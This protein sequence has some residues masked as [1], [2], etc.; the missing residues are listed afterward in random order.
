MGRGFNSTTLD[1]SDFQVGYSIVD[2]RTLQYESRVGEDG[3][4][5]S[6]TQTIS[7]E[8][9]YNRAVEEVL[10]T[11]NTT[12]F[13]SIGDKRIAAGLYIG[14]C[15]DSSINK[16]KIAWYGLKEDGDM[17][18]EANN[19]IMD[20]L[21]QELFQ[22]Y[23]QKLQISWQ[24]ASR[25]EQL[26][27]FWGENTDK[28]LNYLVGMYATKQAQAD[29]E[30][31]RTNVMDF[32]NKLNKKLE[33]KRTEGSEYKLIWSI[34]GL[35]SI[36]YDPSFPIILSTHDRDNKDAYRKICSA[37]GQYIFW[38][39]A[40]KKQ[41]DT[42]WDGEE[43]GPV[44]KS[45]DEDHKYERDF[46]TW[47][48]MAREGSAEPWLHMCYSNYEYQDT[49]G[50]EHQI[51]YRRATDSK[52]LT[53]SIDVG[54][55]ALAWLSKLY[56]SGCNLQ[57]YRLNRPGHITDSFTLANYIKYLGGKLIV[58]TKQVKVGNE[59]IDCKTY[60]SQI[61]LAY[62]FKK[63]WGAYWSMW[64]DQVDKGIVIKTIK[65]NRLQLV[66]ESGVIA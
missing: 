63:L 44:Y 2:G 51:L 3:E 55:K 27:E 19:E 13:L 18:N 48:K 62:Q 37:I 58:N 57:S 24:L 28:R 11:L 9:K 29:Q 21:R 50:N 20:E 1:L 59:T 54:T 8:E 38:S 25:R 34:F 46:S 41:H 22:E 42:E 15:I 16:L 64:Q 35:L 40:E 60:S 66:Q 5:I 43:P 53:A 26:R 36:G 33:R 30:T 10:D 14:A 56:L 6:Y 47:E 7:F 61:L 45:E 32:I 17:G 65:S 23:I 52:E 49:E 4:E 39:L 12:N 31:T